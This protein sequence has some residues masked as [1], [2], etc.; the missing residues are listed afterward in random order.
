MSIELVDGS[1]RLILSSDE[2]TI[3]A[4]SQD[5]KLVAGGVFAGGN[6]INIAGLA[7]VPSIYSGLKT[8]TTN[9]VSE[10]IASGASILGVSNKDMV[11]SA[12]VGLG[13]SAAEAESNCLNGVAGI[14]KLLLLADSIAFV[15]CGGFTHYAWRGSSSSAGLRITQ[16]V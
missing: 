16:G 5:S 9:P 6:T 15:Q 8:L 14:N 1:L 12:Y 11:E 10:A 13:N 7:F 2:H 3:L 4:T